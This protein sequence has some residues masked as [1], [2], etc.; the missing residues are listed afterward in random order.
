MLLV[1]E[2]EAKRV[3]LGTFPKDSVPSGGEKSFH[4][5]WRYAIR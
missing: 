4:H 2:V 1:R 5:I 3:S